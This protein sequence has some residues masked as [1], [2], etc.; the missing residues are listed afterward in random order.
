MN[1]S[2]CTCKKQLV[3]FK[4]QISSGL[5]RTLKFFLRH[6]LCIQNFNVT[7]HSNISFYICFCL[8]F[9]CESDAGTFRHRQF[10][11]SISL[12]EQNETKTKT[13]RF[14]LSFNINLNQFMICFVYKSSFFNCSSLSTFKLTTRIYI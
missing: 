11:C 9:K 14:A 4:F 10:L 7:K 5:K 3:G 12:V 1:T 2:L 6:V 13:K 8:T